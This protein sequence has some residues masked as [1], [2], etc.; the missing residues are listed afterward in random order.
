MTTSL[1][2]FGFISEDGAYI[3][4]HVI[5][6]IDKKSRGGVK[7]ILFIIHTTDLYTMYTIKHENWITSM[8]KFLASSYFLALGASFL[9]LWICKGESSME[10]DYI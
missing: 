5:S 10:N 1:E 6:T 8:L 9:F 2:W 3:L 7:N 4:K